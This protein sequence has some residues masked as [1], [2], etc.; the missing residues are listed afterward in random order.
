MEAALS[1]ETL[2]TQTEFLLRLDQ[3]NVG[4]PLHIY[5]ILYITVEVKLP[6]TTALIRLTSIF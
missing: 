3:N 5:P 1:S 4:T 6:T 2:E